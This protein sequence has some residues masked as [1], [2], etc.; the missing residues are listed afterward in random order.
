MN[1]LGVPELIV[2]VFTLV[3]GLVPFVVMVWAVLTLRE[4]QQSQE[5]IARRLEAIEQLLRRP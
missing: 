1:G 4:V 2:I 5:S 3:L